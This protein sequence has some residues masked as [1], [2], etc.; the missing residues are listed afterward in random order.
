MKSFFFAVFVLFFSSSAFSQM[1]LNGSYNPVAGN[2]F[3]EV[4][5]DT[6]GISEGNSGANQNWNF[7]NLVRLDSVNINWVNSGTTPYAANFPTSNIAEADEQDYYTYFTTSNSEMLYNGS[8][9]ADLQ[10][11]YNNPQILIQFTE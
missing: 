10:I 3:L 5:C 4:N 11:V 2:G 1:T 7:S 9:G 6:N 8:A